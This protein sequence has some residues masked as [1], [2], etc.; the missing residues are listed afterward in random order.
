[1][2]PNADD[3]QPLLARA[4]ADLQG[5]RPQSAE[6]IYRDVLARAPDHPVATHFLGICLVQ[7]GRH[8]EGLALLA[9][10]MRLLQGQAKYRHNYA[11][12]LAQAG[13]LAAAERDPRH[14]RRRVDCRTSRFCRHHRA[15][16]GQNDRRR[17]PSARRTCVGAF[18]CGVSRDLRSRRTRRVRAR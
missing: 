5:G 18:R 12:M 8:Q 3:L 16:H 1:V 4:S 7:T 11:L 14:R 15:A 13:E 6:R 17:R 2:T 10:S 9:H